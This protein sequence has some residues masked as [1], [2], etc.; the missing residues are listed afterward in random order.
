MVIFG[1]HWRR[2]KTMTKAERTQQFKKAFT[3]YR[4]RGYDFA[5]RWTL[6]FNLKFPCKKSFRS[7]KKGGD[8]Q[9]NDKKGYKQ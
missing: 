4:R 1:Q 6:Y 5:Y 8:G 7:L 3:L 2:R 9:N